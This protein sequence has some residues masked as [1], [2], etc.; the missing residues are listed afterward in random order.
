VLDAGDSLRGLPGL[1]DSI[2]AWGRAGQRD[3]TVGCCHIDIAAGRRRRNLRFHIIGNLAVGGDGVVGGSARASAAAPVGADDV[4]SLEEAVG[5]LSS[6][7][8]V[9]E[10]AEA[11][12]VPLLSALLRVLATWRSAR[13]ALFDLV[14]LDSSLAAG[15]F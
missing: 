9:T 13:S 15:V 11:T 7:V 4:L 3:H 2:L 8:L 6:T 10:P 14:P 5:A 1:I 12:R